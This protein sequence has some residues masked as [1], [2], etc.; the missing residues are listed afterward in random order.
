MDGEVYDSEF[1]GIYGRGT[2][3]TLEDYEKYAGISFGRRAVLQHTLDKKDAPCPTFET[4]E[5]YENAFSTPFKHCIDISF[6]SVPHE[7]Y[8]VWAVAFEDEEGNEIHRDDGTQ[9]R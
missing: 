7:D 2:R 9:T 6:D 4:Q 5:E 3:R 8:N 1:F